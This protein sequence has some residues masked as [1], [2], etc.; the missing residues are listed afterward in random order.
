MQVLWYVSLETGFFL[1]IAFLFL[2]CNIN[3]GLSYWISEHHKLK[4]KENDS[5]GCRKQFYQAQKAFQLPFKFCFCFVFNFP[6]LYTY[7]RRCCLLQLLQLSDLSNPHSMLVSLQFSRQQLPEPIGTP[8]FPLFF[9]Y[10]RCWQADVVVVCYYCCCCRCCYYYYYWNSISTA[11]QTT[12][13]SEPWGKFIG[14]ASQ[15]EKVSWNCFI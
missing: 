2:F 3:F 10:R 13:N 15:R 12:A 4:C 11:T 1:S 5:T 7:S 8:H 6:F 9:F 14:N